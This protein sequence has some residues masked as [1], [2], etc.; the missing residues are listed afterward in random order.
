M[1]CEM[2][3]NLFE[4][5][6]KFIDEL[7]WNLCEKILPGPSNKLMKKNWSIVLWRII[8]FLKLTV[9]FKKYIG[10]LRVREIINKIT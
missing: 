7:N 6:K 8:F 9:N 10:I 1:R 5:K 3:D 2:K 4:N